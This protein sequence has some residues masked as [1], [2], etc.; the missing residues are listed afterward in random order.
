V[1]WSGFDGTGIFW[2]TFFG[3]H[4]PN[5]MEKTPTGIGAGAHLPPPKNGKSKLRHKPPTTNQQEDRPM[6]RRKRQ[7]PATATMFPAGDDLPI[8]TGEAP[9]LARYAEFKEEEYIKQESLFDLRPRF[10]KE[11][12]SYTPNQEENRS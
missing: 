8:F 12:P 9:R 5:A 11:E 4:P 3:W 7:Q 6:P 2:E 10:G 1:W